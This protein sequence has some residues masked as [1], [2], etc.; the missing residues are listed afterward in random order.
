MRHVPRKGLWDPP[1]PADHT[2]RTTALAHMTDSCWKQIKQPFTL[3]GGTRGL[4]SLAPVCGTVWSH[5]PFSSNL[6]YSPP[7]NHSR[8]LVS[9]HI[10]CCSCSLVFCAWNAPLGTSTWARFLSLRPFADVLLSSVTEA[11]WA[12]SFVGLEQSGATVMGAMS[13]T[14]SC[15]VSSGSPGYDSAI[16]SFSFT[17]TWHI[18]SYRTGVCHVGC[19]TPVLKEKGTQEEL[20][21]D[22]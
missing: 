13:P 1:S 7:A 14:Q 11:T 2:S 15:M 4:H 3:W 19:M 12:L 9:G 8:L 22:F 10:H 5:Q 18:M 6:W 16:A 20:Q 17:G 21:D